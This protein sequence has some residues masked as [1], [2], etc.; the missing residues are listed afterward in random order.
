MTYIGQLRMELSFMNHR[1][2]TLWAPV[3]R[4][5]SQILGGAGYLL[6]Q[7][8]AGRCDF[9]EALRKAEEVLEMEKG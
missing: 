2:A 4:Y 7:E 6:W 5:L 3:A 8:W 1:D 9:E